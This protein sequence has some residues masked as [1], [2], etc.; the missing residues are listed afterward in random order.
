MQSRRVAPGLRRGVMRPGLSLL[1]VVLAMAMIGLATAASMTA[2]T[3]GMRQAF[4]E[5]VRSDCA[6]YAHSLMLTYLDNIV[7]LDDDPRY[8]MPSMTL[9]LPEYNGRRYRYSWSDSDYATVQESDAILRA[10][11]DAGRQSIS[12][13]RMKQVVIR[14]WLSESSGGAA[15]PGPGVPS[16]TLVRLIDPLAGISRNADSIAKLLDYADENENIDLLSVF[17]SVFQNR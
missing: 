4:R 7:Q 10:R 15:E 8:S 5:Q 13:N 16:A 6:E 14:V 1:E 3:S 2:S 11:A 12:I 17:G 9:E